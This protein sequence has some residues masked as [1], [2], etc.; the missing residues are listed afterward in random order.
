MPSLMTSKKC[1]LLADCKT[2][3]DRNIGNYVRSSIYQLI[4]IAIDNML[5]IAICM[6]TSRIYNHSKQLATRC[7][8][9]WVICKPS[10]FLLVPIPHALVKRL[11]EESLGVSV[12]ELY[13]SWHRCNTRR[14]VHFTIFTPHESDLRKIS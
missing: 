6:I 13:P 5:Y 7:C 8:H 4:C 1:S 11:V 10:S 2:H 3:L 9:F 14:R 12:V